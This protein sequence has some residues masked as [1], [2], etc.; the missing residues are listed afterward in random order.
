MKNLWKHLPFD[1][2]PTNGGFFVIACLF[3]LEIAVGYW[4]IAQPEYSMSLLAITLFPLVTMVIILL[5]MLH[6]DGRQAWAHFIGTDVKCR[7]AA[8]LDKVRDWAWAN[9]KYWTEFTDHVD[10]KGQ[11]YTMRFRS[12]DKAMLA[13][14]AV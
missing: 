13:K 2:N 10:V 14:L 11:E 1:I 4:M 5:F 12:R 3:L 8:H 9:H 6:Y 7:D